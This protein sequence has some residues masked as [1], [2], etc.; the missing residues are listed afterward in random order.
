MYLFRMVFQLNT[1]RQRADLLTMNVILTLIFELMVHN[2]I[3]LM[4]LPYDVV[5]LTIFAKKL[6]QRFGRVSITLLHRNIR[7]QPS[8]SVLR[9]RCSENM[10][11]I[12]NRT[13]A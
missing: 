2:I 7:K 11:Q 4:N 8:K 9:K 5:E 1:F 13:S 12:Y 6:D 10:Q 3:E